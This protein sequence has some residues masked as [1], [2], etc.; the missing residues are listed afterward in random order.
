V[1][2]TTRIA[3]RPAASCVSETF[4]RIS[5]KSVLAA[6]TYGVICGKLFEFRAQYKP[7][8]N[9][10][11]QKTNFINFLKNYSTFYFCGIYSG[12]KYAPINTPFRQDCIR[13]AQGNGTVQ[14]EGGLQAGTEITATSCC[15]GEESCFQRGCRNVTAL[16][17]VRNFCRNTKL[18]RH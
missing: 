3:C 2:E 8:F 1:L 16:R 11:R 5:I 4:Q 18:F 17:Y 14:H 15:D 9:F 7:N 6:V 12:T 10:M 13:R